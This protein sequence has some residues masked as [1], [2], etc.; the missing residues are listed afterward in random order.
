MLKRLRPV[1]SFSARAQSSRLKK[2]QKWEKMKK[3]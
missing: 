2:I 1:N 3:S